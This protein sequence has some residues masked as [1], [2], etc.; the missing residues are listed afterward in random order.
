MTRRSDSSTKQSV[1][2]G[3]SGNEREEGEAGEV[4]AATSERRRPAIGGT[5]SHRFP[6]QRR[7]YK[8]ERDDEWALDVIGKG[9]WQ[10]VG[11]RGQIGHFTGFV[12]AGNLT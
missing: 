1:G 2:C 4:A 8:G 7:R 11:W 3:G 9:R 12:H 10:G 5:C 6:S